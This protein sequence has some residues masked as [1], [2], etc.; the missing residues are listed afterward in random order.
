MDDCGDGRL[1]VTVGSGLR[2]VDDVED[3]HADDGKG[4]HGD[5]RD[6]NHPRCHR[7]RMHIRGP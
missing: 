2:V 4:Q 1:G 3:I 7:T 5:E 6:G